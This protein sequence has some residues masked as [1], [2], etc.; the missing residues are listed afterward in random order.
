MKICTK[1]KHEKPL[2]SYCIRKDTGKFTA[3]C[4]DCRNA[5]SREAY[6]SPNVKMQVRNRAL[7]NIFGIDLNDYNRMFEFQDGQCKTCKRHQSVLSKVLVVDHCHKTN[8]IRGLLCDYC[9]RLLG[10]YENKPELF[11]SFT[12]Y[13]KE[14]K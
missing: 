8:K 6:K 14:N 9:N 7:K 2:A 12:E 5:N 10:N 4:R 1:C 11:L 13:L 3:H